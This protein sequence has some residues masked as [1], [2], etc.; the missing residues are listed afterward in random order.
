MKKLPLTDADTV[1]FTK[2]VKKI[3]FLASVNMGLLEKILHRIDLYQYDS[4][5]KV[6]RQGE[7]GD[8]FYVVSEGRLKVSVR[9]AFFLSR[10][11][12]HFGPE[13]CFGEMALL[14]REPRT[15][16]V[17]CEENSKIFAL[18]A[19]QFDQVLEENPSFA[20][21]IKKLASVRR[22]EL[23]HKP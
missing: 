19:A 9:E 4:G 7:P 5:E 18:Q 16:T 1:Q 22:S 17:I 12:A 21:E 20:Q 15:A 23:K 11:L 14:A 6:C 3:N 8:T 13:D 10:T 2:M